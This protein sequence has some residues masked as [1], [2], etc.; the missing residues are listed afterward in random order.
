MLC[1]QL[2]V[3]EWLDQKWMDRHFLLSKNYINTISKSPVANICHLITLQI[4][5][6]L[7]MAG[8]WPPEI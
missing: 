7:L 6:G 1:K 5:P 8:V 3:F 2:R 4:H